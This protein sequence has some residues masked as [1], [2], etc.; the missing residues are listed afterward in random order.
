MNMY[1][2]KVY[3]EITAWQRDIM[4][5]PSVFNSA[6]S[7]VQG[8]GQKLVPTSIQNV[9]TEGV[10]GL[11][12]TIMFGSELI[13]TRRDI[14]GFNLAE[15]DQLAEEKFRFY[16]KTAVVQGAT[17]GAGG[18]VLGL[19]DFPALMSI[20][21]KFLYELAESYGYDTE[22]KRERLFMLYI[23]QL[24]FSAEK[25]RQKI[26]EKICNWDRNIENFES[27]DWETFQKEYRNYIDFAKALQLL[28]IIGAPAGAIANYNLMGHLKTFAMNC[29]RTRY[30]IENGHEL[31][32][33]IEQKTR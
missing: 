1:E 7:S 20:K 24:A 23:F 10:K 4:K 15:K 18:I 26:F 14:N 21:V 33:E 30:F 5:K 9:I 27:L 17:F 32:K 3:R 28:P 16:E 11:M 25:E 22:D 8:A 2:K 19:A 12:S 29:Y 6:L 13:T 31:F